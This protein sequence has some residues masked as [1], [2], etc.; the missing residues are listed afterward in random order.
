MD[1]F[2]AKIA[3]IF[4]QRRQASQLWAISNKSPLDSVANQIIS[5]KSIVEHYL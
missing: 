2:G 5:S 3:K 1:R 4:G